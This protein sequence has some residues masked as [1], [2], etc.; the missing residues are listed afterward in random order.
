M[1]TVRRG[2]GKVMAREWVVTGNEMGRDCGQGIEGREWLDESLPV[3]YRRIG[4]TYILP[5]SDH[6]SW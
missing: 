5:L 1:F 4:P 6:G 3:R 2:E